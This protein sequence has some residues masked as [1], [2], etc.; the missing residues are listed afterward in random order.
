MKEKTKH[1]IIARNDTNL[2]EDINFVNDFIKIV[3]IRNKLNNNENKLS[4]AGIGSKKLSL[5]VFFFFGFSF[6]FVGLD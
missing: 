4:P 3:K 2:D 5:N 6:D 1:V